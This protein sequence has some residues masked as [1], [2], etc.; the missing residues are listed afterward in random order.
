MTKFYLTTALVALSANASAAG[1]IDRSGQGISPI[2]ETGRYFELSFGAV[3]PK[4][5]GT[6]VLGGSTGNVAADYTQISLA[7]KFD[8]NDKLS[9]AMILD[10]PF[11]ADVLYEPTSLMLG[12]TKAEASSTS[13]S[14]ILR[15]K[16]DGGFSVH[17]GVKADR[18]DGFIRLSG[19]AYG[20]VNGYNVTLDSDVAP[21]FL[22]GVAYEK[23]EIALRIALTYH[24]EIKH[25][26]DTTERIGG[27]QVAPSS[28]TEVKLPSSVNLDVQSGIAKDTLLFGQ[29]RYVDWSAFRVDPAWFTGVT[30]DGLIDLEDTTTFTLGI[31]RRFNEN[32]SG[33]LSFSY[34]DGGTDDLVS[35]L[36][37][38]NGK[39]GVT[40]GAVYTQDNMKVTMGVN[41][42]KAG[43]AR[44]ETG[45]P[46]T[47]R[48]EMTDNDAVGVGVKIGWNF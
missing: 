1:G 25:D 45:T 32:W 34:E 35:P 8:I 44:P 21:G 36:A 12:G 20:P 23:P 46:D 27:V 33:S 37:P 18:G 14:A 47:A 48:A 3:N 24:S 41:Y 26:F 43:D 9:F 39:K 40:L 38:T 5:D 28:V 16:F 22:V 11:G 6:D 31:G 7:Y 19:L 30:G 15:Y 4:V 29:I 42:T 17:G 10:Q 13:L 2:F